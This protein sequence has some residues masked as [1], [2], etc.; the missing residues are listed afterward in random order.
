MGT[1][2]ALSQHSHLFRGGSGQ[3]CG[4]HPH[5]PTALFRGRAGMRTPRFSLMPRV[6]VSQ[7]PGLDSERF[8]QLE[9]LW[10]PPWPLGLG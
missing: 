6:H 9:R 3:G 4:A 7:A 2:S 10:T 5:L 1:R 8:L